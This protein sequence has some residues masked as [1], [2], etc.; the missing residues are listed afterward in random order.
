MRLSS[1]IHTSGIA[2]ILVDGDP[3][4]GSL[5][6]DSRKVIPGSLFV[7][8]KGHHSDGHQFL[9]QAKTNGAV[10]AFCHSMS[11]FGL[12]KSLGLAAMVVEGSDPGLDGT[13]GMAGLPALCRAFFRDPSSRTRLIG[14][15]G[16]NGKTTTAWLLRQA[17]A[18]LGSRPAYIGT[19]GVQFDRDLDPLSNTTPFVVDLTQIVSDLADAGATD[20]AMEVSSHALA[21]G[22][23]D[24]LTFDRAVFTNFTQDHLDFHGSMEEYATAKLRLFRELN[25]GPAIINID[26]PLGDKWSRELDN[27]ITFS[28]VSSS[29]A[30]LTGVPTHVGV[31]TISMEVTSQAEQVKVHSGIG[32]MFN[33]QNLLAVVSTMKTMGFS[34]DE[35]AKAVSICR[36]VP[37]RFE[38][39]PN[40]RGIGVIVDYAHTPDALTKLLLSVRQLRPRRVIT[41]FGCGGDRDRSKR[42]LMAQAAM[43]ASDVTIITSDNPRTENLGQIMSDIL[44]GVIQDKEY[45]VQPHRR[46]AILGAIEISQPGDVVVIAGK[47]HENYQIIGDQKIPFDDRAIA[48]EGL[49]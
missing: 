13:S 38:N 5:V 30:H 12:A 15:T 19:L 42:P 40:D 31:D 23:A 9:Q 47:G 7:C 45:R 26:D 2:G 14:I 25:R 44:A 16:T 41:V 49:E 3:E 1:L 8:L 36:P 29:K 43:S 18:E 48:R 28:T 22:R 20:V 6:A 33:V 32:G 35:I 34:L 24:S 21:E 27:S 10:A 39:I 17:L 37:G 4:I 46:E 11:G